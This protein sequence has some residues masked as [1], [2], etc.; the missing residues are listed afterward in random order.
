[1]PTFLSPA[2]PQDPSALTCCLRGPFESHLPLCLPALHKATLLA[3]GL[4]D[5]PVLNLQMS[6]SGVGHPKTIGDVCRS[7]CISCPWHRCSCLLITLAFKREK[8]CFYTHGEQRSLRKCSPKSC[9]RENY[10]GLE[11]KF[12]LACPGGESSKG[13]S[14]ASA[15]GGAAAAR[16]IG[17]TG[18]PSPA[19]GAAF[20]PRTP[21]MP[22]VPGGGRTCTPKPEQ[23]HGLCSSPGSR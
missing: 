11:E 4:R 12:P 5:A 20:P 18:V 23:E 19:E 22:A 15:I 7:A 2:I 13:A 16:A 21:F 17:P 8:S 1:M 10:A 3:P 14:A 6:A 9:F